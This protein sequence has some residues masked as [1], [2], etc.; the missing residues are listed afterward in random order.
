MKADEIRI[1]PLRSVT[2]DSVRDIGVL[3]S[4]LRENQDEHTTTLPEAQ[5][6]VNDK[7]AVCIVAEDGN[8]IVGMATLYVLQKFGKKTAHVE[9]VVVHSDYRGRGM[10]ESIMKELI[11]AARERGVR[12]LNLTSRPERVAGNRLYQKLGFEPKETN[13]YRLKL[14]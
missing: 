3:L 14:K 4:Q 9:D 12:T 5:E 7:N 1:A 6:I 10:G 8:R 11:Q 13:V 2:E